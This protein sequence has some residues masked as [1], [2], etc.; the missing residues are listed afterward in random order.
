MKDKAD[1]RARHHAHRSG[2]VITC[3][4]RHPVRRA[5]PVPG[6]AQVQRA[7]RPD[8]V[9]RGRPV[10]RVR[11]PARRR[12]VRRHDRVPV[13]PPGRHRP[14]LAN[15]YAQCWARCSPTATS[16]TRSRSRRRGGE[17]RRGRRDLPDHLRRNGR[18]RA[19]DLVVMGGQ[20]DRSPRCSRTATARLSLT[21][22]MGLAIA[23][24]AARATAHA[25]RAG[26]R[27]QLEVAHARPG[28]DPPAFRR[29]SGARLEVAGRGH[30]ER[31]GRAAA[32]AQRGRAA[33]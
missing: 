4:R 3:D 19:S 23:A 32:P 17:D 29:L 20:A 12:S 5:Q 8:R 31:R 27:R 6:A 25:H 15:W 1:S 22:A 21:E 28:P 18:R 24:L 10:Q 26:H 11:E 14:A 7:V 16:R 30:A 13:R 2:V 9:R 33:R